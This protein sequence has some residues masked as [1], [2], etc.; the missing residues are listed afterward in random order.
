M[1]I[2][3]RLV[4]GFPLLLTCRVLTAGVVRIFLQYHSSYT[5]CYQ[6]LNN[7]VHTFVIRIFETFLL[8]IETLQNHMVHPLPNHVTLKN[9]LHGADVVFKHWESHFP[10]CGSFTFSKRPWKF[11]INCI[12][13]S[14]CLINN[15]E[16]V[17]KSTDRSDKYLERILIEIFY[18]VK[19]A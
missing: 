7:D 15:K 8:W 13:L 10:I 5:S 17:G 1:C 12:M 18:T 9:M 16:S 19:Q 2:V 4:P 11:C 6:L 3:Y 14:C